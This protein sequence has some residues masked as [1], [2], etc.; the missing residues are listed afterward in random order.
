MKGHITKMHQLKEDIKDRSNK[1]ETKEVK[2]EIL[3]EANKVVDLLLKEII[4]ISEN[5]T[6]EEDLEPTLEENC[7][8]NY[9]KKE[10]IEIR[11]LSCDLCDFESHIFLASII[12][13]C[14]IIK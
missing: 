2:E 6:V 1:G 7:A 4:E 12:N 14:I 9:E 8:S 13:L 5:N 3:T 10:N 11:E